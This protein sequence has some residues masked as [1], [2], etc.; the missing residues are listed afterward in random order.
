MKT[1][2]INSLIEKFWN[3]ETNLEEEQ[4]LKEYF[5]GSTIAKEHLEYIGYF[6]LLKSERNAGKSIELKSIDPAN[7]ESRHSIAGIIKRLS[8]A[9]AILFSVILSSTLYQQKNI[10]SVA[11][12]SSEAEIKQAYEQTAQ[13]L[14][15]LS[16]TLNKASESIYEIGIIDE[17]KSKIEKKK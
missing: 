13:V 10:P 5:S 16:N 8:I 9:A 1:E 3:G 15:L 11:L 7:K 2:Q 6:Q 12:T 14:A 17:S 4:V